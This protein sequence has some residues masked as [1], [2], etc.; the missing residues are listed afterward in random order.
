MPHKSNNNTNNLPF[1]SPPAPLAAPQA[2]QEQQQRHHQRP[3]AVQRLHGNA[4]MRFR[5]SPGRRR[6]RPQL[7]IRVIGSA[8]VVGR[9]S[10][11]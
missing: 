6:D 1:L 2:Q 4:T 8:F 9:D 5:T 11:V 3:N 7:K 10:G